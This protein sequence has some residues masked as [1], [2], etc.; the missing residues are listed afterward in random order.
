MQPFIFLFC[1]FS[2]FVA[3]NCTFYYLAEGMRL[4]AYSD[5]LVK[6]NDADFVY[7]LLDH[8]QDT[9]IYPL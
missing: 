4:W 5:E 7:V 3:L 8:L 9:A 1:I 2:T 6:Q